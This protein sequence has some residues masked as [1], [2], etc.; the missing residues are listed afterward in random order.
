MSA[1][2]ME[3]SVRS[4]LA[5]R[6]GAR[7]LLE[8]ILAVDPNHGAALLEL[9]NLRLTDGEY[10]AALALF[11]TGKR[12][13]P[14]EARFAE[15]MT[16]CRLQ[17]KLTEQRAAFDPTSDPVTLRKIVA[18]KLEREEWDEALKAME[19]GDQVSVGADNREHRLYFRLERARGFH[20]RGDDAS[21]ITAYQSYLEIA[22]TPIERTSAIL[23]LAA[24]YRLDSRTQTA[25]ELLAEEWRRGNRDDTLTLN[26]AALAIDMK[27][28]RWVRECYEFYLK[29]H[30]ESPDRPRLEKILQTL[31]TEQPH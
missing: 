10:A 8:K 16:R 17:Q 4:R 23:E 31:P 24:L 14:E 21:S 15:A 5:D 7:V 13:H 1:L 19:L 11:E 26:L 28:A 3:A 25:F 29:I 27:D 2:Y 30:P 20:R 6:S 18:R 12:L 22:Q 9:G